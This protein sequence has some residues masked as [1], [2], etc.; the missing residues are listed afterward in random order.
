[1]YIVCYVVNR[2]GG[3]RKKKQVDLSDIFDYYYEK[4]GK[5]VY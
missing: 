4:K 2:D 3:E 5:K 1:M